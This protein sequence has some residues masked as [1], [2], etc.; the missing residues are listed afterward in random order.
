MGVKERGPMMHQA[1]PRKKKEWSV[2]DLP[3]K[4]EPPSN[5][6]ILLGA[7]P[8]VEEDGPC[9]SPRGSNVKKKV[10]GRKEVV[11]GASGMCGLLVSQQD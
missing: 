2:P 11:S 6:S 3:H 10:P 8:G 7:P 4:I 5:G 1:T 9:P